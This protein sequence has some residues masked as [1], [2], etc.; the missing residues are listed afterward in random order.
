MYAR[1]HLAPDTLGPCCGLL[2]ALHLP[3]WPSYDWGGLSVREEGRRI[4]WRREGAREGR[5]NKPLPSENLA[6][7]MQTLKE[8]PIILSP[9]F[10]D[11]LNL[12]ESQQV[13]GTFWAY[14]SLLGAYRSCSGVLF[15]IPL[16]VQ[17]TILSATEYFPTSNSFICQWTIQWVL[18]LS[19]ISEVWKHRDC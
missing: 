19:E 13:I 16:K 14:L 12:K 9:W 1:S 3:D 4:E 10:F 2:R 18:R 11:L 8:A 15:C 5:T 7:L 6:L 17:L